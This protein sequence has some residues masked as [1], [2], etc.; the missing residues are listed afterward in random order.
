L[1]G[2]GGGVGASG[3]GGGIDDMHAIEEAEG[4]PTVSRKEDLKEQA[5]NPDEGT[6]EKTSD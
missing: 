2:G 4:S 6:S 3:G 1:G 5:N